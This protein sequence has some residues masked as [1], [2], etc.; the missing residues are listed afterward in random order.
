MPTESIRHYMIPNQTGYNRKNQLEE[1]DILAL[2]RWDPLSELG[3]VRE[4]LG[5]LFDRYSNLIGMRGWQPAVDLMEDDNAF[6][7]KAEIPGVE[8]ED[9]DIT[10]TDTSITLRGSVGQEEEKAEG[11]IRSERRYGEFTRM[12]T[13][14]A[15]IKPNDAQA[16]FRNGLL[17][18]TLP[19]AKPG[20]DHG[21]KVKIDR[22]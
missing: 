8:P 22:L 6:V 3:P 11:Y 15:E 13:L 17:T 7:L 9:V 4:D 14:P 12:V 20:R 19:K 2:I 16:T 1:E 5:R 10:V 18:V 21:I